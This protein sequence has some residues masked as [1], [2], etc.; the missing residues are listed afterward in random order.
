[1]IVQ[2]NCAGAPIVG[3]GGVTVCD[4]VT[5]ALAVHPVVASVTVT[6]Y[7]PGVLTEFVCNV[8]PPLHA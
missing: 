5:V 6:E 2:V 7:G 8:P 4:T 3:A 1:M